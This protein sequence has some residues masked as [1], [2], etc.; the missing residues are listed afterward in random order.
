MP[1]TGIRVARPMQ[2]VRTS[3][4]PVAGRVTVL[5]VEIR[6]VLSVEGAM[7]PQSL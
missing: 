1:E 6:D 7:V 2:S 4:L 5:F 3:S